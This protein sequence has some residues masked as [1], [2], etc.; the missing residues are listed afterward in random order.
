MAVGE[1]D[2]GDAVGD[3]GDGGGGG[4]RRSRGGPC[5]RVLHSIRKPAGVAGEKG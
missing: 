1:P 3:D 5:E 4:P 2:T